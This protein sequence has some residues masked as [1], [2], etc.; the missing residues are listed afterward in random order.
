MSNSIVLQLDPSRNNGRN[1]EATFVTLKGGRILL[2]WSRFNTGN[3]SD[4]G[5]CEIA[6][7]Y[8]D[9]DG[10]TWS[11]RD[12]VMV[13]RD[14][15]ASNVMSPSLLRLKDGRIA[16]LTLRKEGGE[17]FCSP[18]FRTSTNEA[19]SF[20][21]PVRVNTV[22]GYYSV[23]N[24]RMVQ[25]RNGRIILP[26]GMHRWRSPW[27]LKS[28]AEL[29]GDTNTRVP[30]GTEP[31][32]SSPTLIFFYFSDDGGRTWL[33]S[34][35]NYYWCTPKG[36]GLQEPGLIQLKD[37]RLW[38]WARPGHI[39]V[40]GMRDVQWESF[41]RDSG[42]VWSP[43]RRSQF[44]SP[45]SP[46]QVKR[47]P[48]TGHLLAVWNDTSRRFKTPKAKPISWGRTPLVSAISTNEGRTWK[49]HLLIEDAPDHGFCYPAIHF[50][51]EAVLLSYNAGGATTRDPLD[52]QRVR[53]M[54]YD[55]LY[56]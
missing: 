52:T 17:D 26:V 18:W 39:G 44:I 35:T 11:T 22:P 23:N 14:Q 54:T 50:T 20:S 36:H 37:G 56:A 5:S 34:L 47:I 13:G 19:K 45:S 40:E 38:S 15:G 12:M 10:W 31:V 4:S 27:S 24:D 2:A 48:K 8:S 29:P 32:F 55:T 46:L 7:R 1:S 21:K 9:D 16:L 6:S 42:Q 51:K 33:E 28:E 49:H 30:K 53:R 43:P 41:S 25:L 3:H